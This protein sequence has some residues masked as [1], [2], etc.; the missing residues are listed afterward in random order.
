[1]GTHPLGKN[2]SSA[3]LCSV[4]FEGRVV[5]HYICAVLGGNGA[6]TERA[7]ALSTKSN[8]RD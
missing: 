1:M 6:T 8:K 3:V 5:Q 7:N 2:G 4:I